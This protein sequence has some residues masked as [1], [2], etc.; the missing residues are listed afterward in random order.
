MR[1][2]FGLCCFCLLSLAPLTGSTRALDN[3][4]RVE[5]GLLEGVTGSVPGLRV[6][7]GIPYAAPPVGELRWRPPQPPAKWEGV[8]KADK[9]SDSCMQNLS[10]SHN[11]WTAEFMPQNQA[12][13]D[14]LCL[15]VWTSANSSNERRP[16]FV[17][18]HGG[19]FT[20]GSGEV[21]VYDGAELAKKGLVVVTINY[22]LGVFGFLTHPEL[23]GES[24]NKASG[25]YGLLDMVAALV[26]TRKNIAAFGGDPQRVTIAG[27]SAGASAVH[28]LTASPLAKGLFHRAIAESGSGVGRLT[29]SQAKTENDGVKF[30]ESKGAHSIRELRALSA[31]DLIGGGMRFGPVIDGWFLPA[32]INAIFAQGKQ[33]DAPMMTGL[34]ADEGSASPDYGKINAGDFKKQSQKRFG[35]LAKT[36][37]KYYPSDDDAQSRMSQKQSARDQGMISMSIWAR[38]RARTS[39]TKTWTYYFSRAIP[40]PEQPQ[41][42]AFHSSELP[43]V[44]GNLKLINR[45]WEP[46]DRRL[47][48]TMMA[49]WV[50]FA[51]AGDPNGQGLPQWP[52]FDKKNLVTMELGE[53]TGMRPIA[54][55]DRVSFFEKFFAKRRTP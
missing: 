43:Y 30:A 48:E 41:Y 34:T 20:E 16:V 13:E 54:D 52:A 1:K 38:E 26:W 9:F 50:N 55:T 40:W 36:F 42:G 14:C 46:I 31:S 35:D 15:N 37:F 22:R 21:A 8:R 12:S 10:R 11:P 53:K 5:S 4:V 23:T 27:Q 28:A 18:I 2:I 6:F 7:K 19:A 32:D 49:Y 29:P 51:T 17:W 3:T 44:F 33:N 24:S 45:P 25:N 39:K 47:S